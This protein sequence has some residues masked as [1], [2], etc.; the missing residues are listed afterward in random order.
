MLYLA[1]H[2]DEKRRVGV[3][4]ISKDLG[5]PKHF[6]AKILQHLT[7]N[8]LASSVKGRNGGF[9][10][11]EE[12]KSASLLTVIHSLDGD[13]M[14]TGCILGL[15]VCSEENPCTFHS[16]AKI[17][18]SGMVQMLSDKSIHEIAEKID[19]NKIVI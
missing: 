5:L 3:E 14:F 19:I 15:N 11:S 17:H 16:Q 9:Y 7:K 6:L 10:L 4:E 2:T 18:R 8:K 1:L 12:N 13:G